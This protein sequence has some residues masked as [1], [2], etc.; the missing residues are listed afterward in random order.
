MATAKITIECGVPA[1]QNLT[2]C[3]GCQHTT[4]LKLG[5]C[6]ICGSDSVFSLPEAL[7]GSLDESRAQALISGEAWIPKIL[8]GLLAFQSA[9]QQASLAGCET[10]H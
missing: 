7:N 10:H 2:F 6:A 5:L 8:N 4:T 3:A 9:L 1:F